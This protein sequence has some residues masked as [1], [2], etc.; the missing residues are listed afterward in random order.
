MEEKTGGIARKSQGTKTLILHWTET[1]ENDKSDC[2]EYIAQ[3][4]PFVAVRVGDEIER[5]VETL[6]QY[7]KLG[8]TGRK[9]GT[10][11]LVIAGT[12]YIAIYKIRV[13]AIYILR[14]LHGARDWK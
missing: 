3:D 2:V 8:R 10:R 7:P 4:N 12:P 9:N 6:L 11:E 14:I 13:D 5:Q 1:A